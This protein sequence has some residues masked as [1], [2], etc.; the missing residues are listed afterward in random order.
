M[1]EWWFANVSV[2]SHFI[3]TLK[4]VAKMVAN[5]ELTDRVVDIVFT[6]FDENGKI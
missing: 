3:G 2:S 6:L 1:T 5:V 4:H